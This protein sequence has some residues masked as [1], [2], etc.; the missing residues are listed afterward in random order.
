MELQK[1]TWPEVETYLQTSKTILIPIGSTEQHGPTGMMG[2]DSLSAEAIALELGRRES[3]LVAPTI[4]VGMATHHMAFA[5]TITLQPETLILVICDYVNS[6]AQH[7]FDDFIFINGHGGN[8]AC[9][10]AAFESLDQKCRYTNWYMGDAIQVLRKE[11]YGNQEGFH[12]TPSE[13]AL[14]QFID[15]STIREENLDPVCAPSHA[16]KG[17]EEMRTFHPDG[18]IGSNVS[19]ANPEHGQQLFEASLKDLTALLSK[20]R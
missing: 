20:D 10:K 13:I 19:L 16:Y 2:T 9:L 18:R 6:L 3:I 15:P 7:G 5:G 4:N 8:V 12:A 11:L 1:R 14:V 17:P